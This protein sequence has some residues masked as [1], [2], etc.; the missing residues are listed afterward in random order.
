MKK[1]C[2][3]I[4]VSPLP[5]KLARFSTNLGGDCFLLLLFDEIF[6]TLRPF[7]CKIDKENSYKRRAF[8]VVCCSL[9][10]KQLLGKGDGQV[11]GRLRLCLFVCLFCDNFYNAQINY[12]RH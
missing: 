11:E 12:C 3:M 8:S 4:V 9:F 7:L 5:R 6:T 1:T 10:S 2:Q